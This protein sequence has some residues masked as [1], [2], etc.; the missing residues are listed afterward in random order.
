[1]KTSRKRQKTMQAGA[2][3]LEVIGNAG[4]AVLVVKAQ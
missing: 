2:V 4:C 1:M 3:E